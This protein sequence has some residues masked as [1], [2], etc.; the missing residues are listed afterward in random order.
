MDVPRQ[1]EA[2]HIGIDLMLKTM[3]QLLQ[4]EP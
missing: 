1:M 4:Y 2:E 3:K